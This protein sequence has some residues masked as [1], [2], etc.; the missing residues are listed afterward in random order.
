[1]PRNGKYAMLITMAHSCR[2]RCAGRRLTTRTCTPTVRTTRSM[3]DDARY[4]PPPHTR[5]NSGRFG[6]SA[7]DQR[8]GPGQVRHAHRR[9]LPEVSLPSP[10]VQSTQHETILREHDWNKLTYPRRIIPAYRSR[11]RDSARNKTPSDTKFCGS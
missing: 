4:A 6:D 7:R 2:Q 3:A 8:D 1:M 9:R 11:G 5:R 10:R